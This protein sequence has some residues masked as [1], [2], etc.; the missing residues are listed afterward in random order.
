MSDWISD[1]MLDEMPCG[2]WKMAQTYYRTLLQEDDYLL[3]MPVSIL[4][5]SVTVSRCLQVCLDFT[6]EIFFKSKSY[7]SE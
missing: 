6:S 2:F 3:S 1:Q 7:S 5:D 4:L